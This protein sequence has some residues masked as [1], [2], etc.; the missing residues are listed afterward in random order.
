MQSEERP[1]SPRFSL[2]VG[3]PFHALLRRFGGLADDGLPRLGAALLLATL[4]WMLPALLVVAEANLGDG[5]PGWSFFAD[6]TTYGRYLIAIVV[7]IGTERYADGR[8]DLL[9]N[10]FREARIVSD[11][12]TLPFLSALAVADRR[13]SSK[14]AELVILVFVLG[15][16]G[17]STRYAAPIVPMTWEGQAIDG[18]VVL[19]W[20]GR[21]TS[22]VSSPLFLF[23]VLRW[24]W[25]FV[26]WTI[27][28]FRLS[29][30]PLA[31]SPLHP[32]RCAGLGFLAIYPSIFTGF[33]FAASSVVAATVLKELTG[34]A[35]SNESIG[36]MLAGWLAIMLLLF[37]GPLF[38]FAPIIREER[39]RALLEYGRL[40]HQHHAAFHRKWLESARDGADLIASADAS[41]LADL[42]VSVALIHEIRVVP[43][44]RFALIQ[45]IAAAGLPLT[46]VVLSQVPLNELARRILLGIL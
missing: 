38:V 34:V 13:S 22:L 45:L 27:L 36:G 25:R 35:L 29:R 39:E 42:T 21:F 20:A 41:S 14:L 15:F 23:L 31:L 5:P 2:V 43:I 37:L 40:T 8:F 6:A 19:S 24:C 7:M 16:A 11:D 26:V 28:L 30:L 46:V 44:D 33:V 18:T 17:W 10:Q 9:I 1:S 3:G 4:A 32:D 12:H